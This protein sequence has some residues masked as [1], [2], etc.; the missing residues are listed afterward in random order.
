MTDAA[1]KKRMLKVVFIV[2]QTI[3]KKL[4]REMGVLGIYLHFIRMVD[5]PLF[6][7]LFIIFY[8]KFKKEM[9]LKLCIQ[10]CHL[11]T[12]LYI[13]CGNLRIRIRI[14]RQCLNSGQTG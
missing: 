1:L 8:M 4:Q 14:L 12:R 13:S 7:K 9:D 11:S 3:R 10:F 5:Y 6:S 2:I